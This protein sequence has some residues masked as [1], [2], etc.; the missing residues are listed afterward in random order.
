[1]KPTNLVKRVGQAVMGATLLW[2]VPGGCGALDA[3]MFAEF[4][5]EFARTALAAWLL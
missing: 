2:M 3:G 5:E 1:M 4:A